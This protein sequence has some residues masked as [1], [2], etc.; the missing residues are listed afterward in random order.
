[1][2]AILGANSVSGGYEIDNSLRFNNDDS[3]K[4]TF[5]PGSAG[6]RRTFT[7]SVWFKLQVST[8]SERVLLAADDGTGENNNFDYIAVKSGDKI[9][10][11]GYEGSENQQVISTQVLRDPSAWYH[12]VVAFDTTQG[13]A[14]NRI[15]VYLN[16][17][18]ITDFDTA[19]Y[20]SENFQTRINNANAQRISSYPD[21]DD[22]Y[23]DGYMAEYNLIDGQQLTPSDFGEFNDNGVWIPKAYEGT[24]GTNGFY[25]EFKET[26]T[27]TDASGMGADTSGNDNH[28]AVTNLAATDVTTDTPTNNFATFN[29]L[30][31]NNSNVYTEGNTVYD[32]TGNF[33]RCGVSSL[34][35]SNGKWYAE[36]KRT[37]ATTIHL[38]GIVA[39]NFVSDGRTVTDTTGDHSMGRGHTGTLFLVSTNS[40]SDIY[41]DGSDTSTNVD[42]TT[43]SNDIIMVAFDADS[44]KI[45]FGKNGTWSSSGD[46]AAGSDA[47]DT[48]DGTGSAP[49]FFSVGTENTQAIQGNFGNPAF[50]I[51]SGNADANG[52]GNFEYAV[53]SGY[54]SLCTKN[55]AEFG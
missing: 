14:A 46:P 24:Y 2:V 30:A 33:M 54:Y 45:W 19:N 38:F 21:Q 3:P 9:L 42:F 13:T 20:P 28:W 22:S 6:N 32:Y 39:D 37:D 23:F 34:G 12:L 44:K 53:P 43:T 51:A 41:L 47:S 52:Y 26:G 8:T 4:L 18:Q 17:L 55:L 49:F 50:A 35:V 36:F 10:V 27:G 1:M 40:T 25:L 7:L 31:R 11:Y 29:P 5:T 48:Y 16:G 15:K